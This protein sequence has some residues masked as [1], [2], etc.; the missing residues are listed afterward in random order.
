M[1][2]VIS[3]FSN[4][5]SWIVS[6]YAPVALNSASLMLDLLTL[7]FVAVKVKFSFGAVAPLLDAYAFLMVN[8]PSSLT[9]ILLS[10]LVA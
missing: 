1:K 2:S 7:T 6:S 8:V 9:A 4:V 3:P 10:P 5:A